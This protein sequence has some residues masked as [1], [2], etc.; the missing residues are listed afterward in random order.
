MY[1]VKYLFI[2]FCLMFIKIFGSSID[3]LLIIPKALETFYVFN[4][5]KY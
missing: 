1:T 4:G 2:R 5:G 3:M